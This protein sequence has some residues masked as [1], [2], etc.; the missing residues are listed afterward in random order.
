MIYNLR[1]FVQLVKNLYA[2]RTLDLRVAKFLWREFPLPIERCAPWRKG[3]FET[4]DDG[5][6]Q[7]ILIGR[8]QTMEMIITVL[9][10]E[11]GHYRDCLGMRIK[12]LN[13]YCDNPAPF[14]KRAWKHAL[15]FSKQYRLPVDYKAAVDALKEGYDTSYRVLDN[16]LKAA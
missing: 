15:R 13:R 16:K 4:D 14:E 9:L 1:L 7:R 10:H 5:N 12:D 11:V 3:A 2:L 6:P 8:N